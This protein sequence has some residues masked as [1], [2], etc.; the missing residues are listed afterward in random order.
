MSGLVIE[1]AAQPHATV[2][3][4]DGDNV[5]GTAQA[6]QEGRW[7]VELMQPL[8]EGEHVF[9]AR[10]KKGE[11]VGDPSAAVRVTVLINQL[12]VTGGE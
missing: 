9:T 12:P 5:L 4:Y 3:V 1:G 10:V 6:D 2:V 8:V 7:R 11:Q